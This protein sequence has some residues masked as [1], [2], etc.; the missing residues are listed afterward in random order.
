MTP[1]TV[2]VA[3]DYEE[4]A[5]GMKVGVINTGSEHNKPSDPRNGEVGFF[6]MPTGDF[7]IGSKTYKWMPKSD[8]L[9]KFKRCQ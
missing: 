8:F 3:S 9:A 1:S 5:T 4:I 6:D 2:D 7:Q